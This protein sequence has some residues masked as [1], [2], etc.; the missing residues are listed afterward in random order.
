MSVG[1]KKAG[2]CIFVA[3]LA[4]HAGRRLAPPC[5]RKKAH[6]SLL[7]S[8]ARPTEELASTMMMNIAAT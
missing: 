1:R 2:G 7:A 5:V 4:V 3:D 8:L 6:D